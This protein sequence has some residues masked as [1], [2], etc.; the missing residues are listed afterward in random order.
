MRP[1]SATFGAPSERFPTAISPRARPGSIAS[2]PCSRDHRPRTHRD[3][4]RQ[5]RGRFRHSPTGWAAPPARLSVSANIWMGI[6][7][8]YLIVAGGLVLVRTVVLAIRKGGAGGFLPLPRSDRTS[9]LRGC[10]ARGGSLQGLGWN[11]ARRNGDG[12]RVRKIDALQLVA[13]GV[14]VRLHA[15]EGQPQDLGNFLIGLSPGRP[16]QT[17]LFAPRQA[18]ERRGQFEI[19]VCRRID[20][21]RQQLQVHHL[22]SLISNPLRSRLIAGEGYKRVSPPPVADRDRQAIAPDAM[23]RGVGQEGERR[24]ILVAQGLP[25]EWTNGVA[26]IGDDRIEGDILLQEV[27]RLPFSRVGEDPGQQARV[28]TLVRRKPNIGDMTDADF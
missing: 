23:V 11:D 18:D 20:K 9:S 14:E 22:I 27:S 1:S 21:N 26:G 5:R 7:R 2:R 25:V 10:S 19:D 12:D 3:G 6:L 17:L 15:G 8:L 16:D 13:G 4:R 24:G 28:G